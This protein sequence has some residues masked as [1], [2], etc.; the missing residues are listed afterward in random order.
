MIF[1]K[2]FSIEKKKKINSRFENAGQ[3]LVFSHCRKLSIDSN[4]WLNKLQLRFDRER[5]L[6]KRIEVG[7]TLLFLYFWVKSW[8]YSSPSFRA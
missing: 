8:E 2:Y 1:T 6:N 5:K 3:N 4:S 7:N